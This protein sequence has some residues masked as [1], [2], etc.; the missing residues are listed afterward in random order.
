MNGGSD[1]YKTYHFV[2][3]CNKNFQMQYV[4]C[5]TRLSKAQNCKKCTFLDNLR[6]I[7]PEENI[8]TRQM[9]PFFS[10]TFSTL[11]VCNIHFG[12]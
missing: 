9:T 12:K 6:T 4:N 2:K 8:K 7:T 10:F 3:E 1:P 5:F 11:T